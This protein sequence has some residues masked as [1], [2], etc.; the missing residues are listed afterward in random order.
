MQPRV[1]GLTRE[2]NASLDHRCRLM[3]E[4]RALFRKAC[5]LEEPASEVHKLAL[6]T[7]DGKAFRAMPSS[8]SLQ[9]S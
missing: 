9:S 2:E 7:V 8:V 3:C 4:V 1:R 5:A 6:Q